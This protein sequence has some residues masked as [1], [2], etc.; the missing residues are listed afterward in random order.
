MR[1]RPM[2]LRSRQE[3]C[4]WMIFAEWSSENQL[5]S[6]MQWP[7]TQIDQQVPRFPERH[8]LGFPRL[9]KNQGETFN[10]CTD[11][12]LPQVPYSRSVS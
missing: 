1:E 3:L 8:Q 11:V 4:I 9:P 5:Y 12:L 2:E 7:H 6:F 10:A